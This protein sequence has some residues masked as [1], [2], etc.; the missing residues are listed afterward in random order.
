MALG[1]VGNP[2][3]EAGNRMRRRIRNKKEMSLGREKKKMS[4]T[5]PGGSSG[6][7]VVTHFNRHFSRRGKGGRD[8]YQTLGEPELS[9]GGKNFARF[10]VK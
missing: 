10:A 1:F 3:S 8:R 7:W 4:V 2:S 5:K 9:K 6:V